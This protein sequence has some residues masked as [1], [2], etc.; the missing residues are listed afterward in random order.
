MKI[1][2]L[3]M[4]YI[5]K[6]LLRHKVFDIVACSDG[7][8]SY[9]INE[10]KRIFKPEQPED[11]SNSS[12]EVIYSFLKL[13]SGKYCISKAGCTEGKPGE[14]FCHILI[15][16]GYL[17]FYP[18]QTFGSDL[19]INSIENI[20]NASKLPVL[21]SINPGNILTYEK[22]VEFI[23]QN[24]GADFKDMLN[25]AVDF[26]ESRKPI[27]I[28]DSEEN[29]A[30]WIAALQMSLSVNLSHC[31]TYT[32]G[33][34]HNCKEF[35]IKGL[36]STDYP[37]THGYVFDYFNGIM[38]F[39][40]SYYEFSDLALRGF[41]ESGEDIQKVKQFLE[42]TD[43]NKLNK[44]IDRCLSLYKMQNP[45]NTNITPNLIKSGFEFAANIIPSD[46]LEDMYKALEPSLEVIS[47]SVDI[48][49]AEPLGRFLFKTAANS[50]N[51][52]LMEKACYYF[53]ASIDILVLKNT[54]DDLLNILKIYQDIKNEFDSISHV[55][56]HYSVSAERI[57][58]LSVLLSRD[59]LFVKSG[60][61]LLMTINNLIELGYTYNQALKI[62][63]MEKFIAGC[64]IHAAKNAEYST[65]ILETS[66]KN[67]EYFIN[68]IAV[69]YEKLENKVIIESFIDTYIS[70]IDTKDE[71][72]A[73]SIRKRLCSLGLENLI[74]EECCTRLKKA[75]NPDEVFDKLYK[76]IFMELPEVTKLYISDVI[77]EYL[78]LL[79]AHKL[80][81]ECKDILKYIFEANLSLNDD[82]LKFT[83][84]GFESGLLFTQFEADIKD[85][86]TRLEKLKNTR[87]ITTCP[88]ITGLMAFAL[89]AKEHLNEDY[90]LDEI[91]YEPLDLEKLGKDIYDSYLKLCLP[92][93][94][95]YAKSPVDH[96][97][98]VRL[99][100][101]FD[102]GCEFFI[103][104]I[105][106]IKL[107][108]DNDR[109]KGYDVLLYFIVYFF[110]FLEP[111]YKLQGEVPLID[112]IRLY[113]IDLLKTQPADMIMQLDSDMI[114][115]FNRMGLSLPIQWKDM[116]N[117]ILLQSR[118]SL[119]KNLSFFKKNNKQL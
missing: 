102:S 115:E 78:N 52:R 87:G 60:F 28:C 45:G 72:E 118:S 83:I 2:Q 11:A 24:R 37:D 65:G 80:Y 35:V 42:F 6:G 68:I 25:A 89:F 95:G 49:S 90:T 15:V 74:F 32:T 97:K 73:F 12:Y 1:Y 59:E 46:I 62:E 13:Q 43:C 4:A 8:C 61:Y 70:V 33:S 106:S 119:I 10:I 86:V 84:S 108:L 5:K 21:E 82:A 36:S 19:F 17:P 23:K 109:K 3:V 75:K 29:K 9:E 96:R 66:G 30:M 26:E 31:L 99:F 85:I 117:S 18:V 103:K 93:V 7:L 50:K 76:E 16:D 47:R 111:R 98:I 57:N 94:L 81:N 34:S 56:M 110:Y 114:E 38:P 55:V 41:M 91:L 54:S 77:K 63:G 40:N 51:A 105:D 92:Y 39:T 64:S 22:V 107:L 101:V 69:L 100:N 104:Y 67:T 79:P 71:K 58:Y 116:Y 48:Y 20:K 14:Y 88:D 27:F 113:I 53:Y 112:S 44:D